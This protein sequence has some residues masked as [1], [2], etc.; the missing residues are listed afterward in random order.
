MRIVTA[1]VFASASV[2]LSYSSAWAA[3]VTTI[4]GMH[5]PS[6]LMTGS[7]AQNP[8]SH[9]FD[10]IQ[11]SE[12]QR[13]QMRDLMQQTQFERPPVNVNDLE[14]LH[15]LV[16]AEKFNETAVK[17]QAEKLA[18]AQVARQVE[19]SKIRNQMYHLLT[20][21]QQAVLQKKHEQRMNELRRLTNLQQ[22]PSLHD[23]SS[24]GSNQ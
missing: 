12:Q 23:A 16:I 11:L 21:Q 14:T 22:V 18:Q 9:M 8:Q 7:I 17:A 4:D 10:G 1:A 3:D 5:Q 13:Q 19:M 6:E 24:T 20:P 2:V 15:N